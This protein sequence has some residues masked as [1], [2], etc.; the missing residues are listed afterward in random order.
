MAHGPQIIGDQMRL[1]RR[2]SGAMRIG[3]CLDLNPVFNRRARGM[4]DLQ[5]PGVRR[6]VPPAELAHVRI[7]HFVCVV[8]ARPQH[9]A[10]RAR[11]HSSLVNRKA[12]SGPQNMDLPAI[13]GGKHISCM[14]QCSLVPGI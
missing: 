14:H 11:L 9:F 1:G 7:Q 5:E 3:R 8:G 12:P 2:R 10:K 6:R 4:L 13:I